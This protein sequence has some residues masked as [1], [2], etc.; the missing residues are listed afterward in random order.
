MT[1]HSKPP[2]LLLPGTLCNGRLFAPMLAELGDHPTATVAISGAR[3]APDMARRILR[4]APPRFAL[5][6]FSLGGIVA[7]EMIA[8]APERVTRLALISTTPR[9]DPATNA[10]PRRKAVVRASRFGFD[11]Y[12]DENWHA[13]VGPASR[14]DED[15]KALVKLMARE[16]GLP[17]F[18]DQAEIAIN[19]V[20]SR[21][22]LSR[23]K[24]PTLIVAGRQEAICPVHVHQEIAGAVEGS[25]LVLVEAGHFAP[26]EQPKALGQAVAAWLG[27]QDTDLVQA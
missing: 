2:L 20:D 9:P 13:F 3:S 26:L 6:G 25:K 18:A 10:A 1:A 22:R 23:I 11:S 19:R 15:M 12:T 7:M 27:Q 4:D 21:P 14:A 16:V 24:V 8:Q 5:L 17:A